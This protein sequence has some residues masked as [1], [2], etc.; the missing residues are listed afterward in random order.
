MGQAADQVTTAAGSSSNLSLKGTFFR[1]PFLRRPARTGNSETGIPQRSLKSKDSF[2]SLKQRCARAVM[3]SAAGQLL[4]A[5]RSSQSAVHGSRSSSSS[6]SAD[7]TSSSSI[8][9]ALEQLPSPRADESPDHDDRTAA[10]SFRRRS[11]SLYDRTD[12]DVQ[13]T[14]SSYAAELMTT[15]PE[16]QPAET[17]HEEH[18]DPAETAVV[19]SDREKHFDNT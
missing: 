11:F 19:S 5:G 2:F 14:I 17:E 7:E 8:S 12:M 9:A 16:S 10:D 18:L 3:E 13:S 15:A 1:P 4:Q 6:S